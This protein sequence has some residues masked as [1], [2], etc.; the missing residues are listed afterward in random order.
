MSPAPATVPDKR[1]PEPPAVR[2][3]A[4]VRL[5]VLGVAVV[6]VIAALLFLAVQIRRELAFLNNEPNENIH[7]A[8][9]QL[10]VDGLALDRAVRIA[11]PGDAAALAETRKRFDLFYK[12]VAGLG[13]GESADGPRID[14]ARALDRRSLA[15]AL[16]DWAPIID[17]SDQILGENLPRLLTATE[18][19]LP[20]A[21]RIA[22]E[23]ASYYEAAE[24]LEKRTFSDL[25]IMTA[26]A[27]L[28]LILALAAGALALL[29]QHRIASGR[30]R[31]IEAISQRYASTIN[32]SLDAI[33]V[34][35]EKGEVIDFNPAAERTFGFSREAALGRDMGELIVPDHLR[36]AH[37]IGLERLVRGGET[38]VVNRGRVTM[39]AKRANGEVFPVELSLGMSRGPRGRIFIGYIRDISDQARAQR[40]LTDARDKALAAVRAKSQFLAIMSHEM[41]TPLNGVLAILDIL[42][43]TK[44]TEKQARFVRTAITSGEILQRHINDVLEITHLESGQLRLSRS[45]FDPRALLREVVAIN[46]P[47]AAERGNRILLDVS[48]APAHILEDHQRLTQVLVNL[49][50]NAVKFTKN[51]S[52]RIRCAA[53]ARGSAR[54]MLDISV[55]DTGMGI[56]PSDTT[57]IFEDFVSLDSSHRPVTKGYG[58]GLAIARRIVQAMEGEIGVESQLGSGSR[59]WLRLPLR[60]AEPEAIAP[61]PRRPASR[62]GEGM[63]VLLVE[64]N[65]TN[66]L[67]A[68]E[69]LRAEGCSVAEAVDGRDG[70]NQAAATAFDLILMDVSMPEVDGL[71]ATRRIR[72]DMASLSRSTPIVGLTAHALPEEQEELRRA[73]MEECLIK[74]LRSRNLRDLVDRFGGASMK[75]D[76]R[77][78]AEAELPPAAAA[79][80]LIDAEVL[81]ELRDVLPEDVFA[82]RIAAFLA[83]LATIGDVLRDHLSREEIDRI[84]KVAHKFAGAA[85][86]F[87]AAPLRARLAE[88]ETAARVQDKAMLEPLVASVESLS[89]GTRQALTR[90]AA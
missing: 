52:I 46:A 88:L 1:E 25:L 62:R 84:G 3:R 85:A 34:S 71:E 11:T 74:P 61:E 59:F 5:A 8:L 82:E 18:A 23:S 56:A 22:M 27:A 47:S 73:G 21:R 50:S 43:S 42:E 55:Q 37:R 7:W 87:G 89:E 33:I 83:E 15:G 29:A 13:R 72:G 63:R 10:E 48:D 39:E 75:N 40:E 32:A 51:G 2:A 68:S 38:R 35:D 12:R 79:T 45:A 41:R 66:R 9:A 19:A 30:S 31:D 60:E 17:A 14:V 6:A 24:E 67:V 76:D 90:P 28:G 57:R 64:D 78:P 65:E 81:D 80:P 49:I 69:M 77:N 58:L 16:R 36:E 86:L 70:A 53:D 4:R 54:P 26:A 44:L 20:L